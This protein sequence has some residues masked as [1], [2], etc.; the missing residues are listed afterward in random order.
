MTL[1]N[2]V[3][4]PAMATRMAEPDYTIGPRLREYHALR[5]KNGC[6]LNITEFVAVHESS[7]FPCTPAIYEDRFI[8]GFRLL[9]EELHRYG[10]RLCVQLWHAGRQTTKEQSG[11]DPAAPSA[12]AVGPGWPVPREL[13][14]EEIS[15]LVRAFGD[16]A[17][18]AKQAGADA[19]EIH[20][21][22]GYLVG[23]FV[24]AW[25]NRRK[26]RY[27]GSLE[28]RMTFAVEIIREIRGRVG[29]DFPLIYRM[30]A[31]E[32][33]NSPEA[34]TTPQAVA[35]AKIVE[36]AGV[37]AVHVSIGT[38]GDMWDMIPP[39]Q[40]TPGFNIP[41]AAAVKAA[42]NI[43]V[44]AVGR[45]NFPALADA[46]LA[47]GKADFV[48]I[49][50]GQL[51]DPEFVKKARE[52]RAE[53]IVKCIGC[54]Q[55]CIGRY[56]VSPHGPHLTCLQNPRCGHEFLS[57]EV[58]RVSAQDRIEIHES[59]CSHPQNSPNTPDN[60]DFGINTAR[61]NGRPGEGRPALKRVLVAGG[62]IAGLSAARFLKA[63]GHEVFLYEEQP[64]CGGEFLLAGIPP[65]KQEI[66]GAVLWMIR[67]AALEGITVHTGCSVDAGTLSREKPEV[68]ILA[69]GARPIKPEI[70]GVERALFARD[71]LTG[72]VPVGRQVVIIG[73]GLVGCET[74]EYLTSLGK[75]VVLVE[76]LD[77]LAPKADTY[78]RHYIEEYIQK[79]RIPVYLQARCLEIGPGRMTI[80]DKANQEQALPADTVVIAA[81]YRSRTELAEL[82]REQGIPW[83]AIGDA[84]EPRLA[85]DAIK[86]AFDCAQTIGY[87]HP[88]SL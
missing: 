83:V 48:S 57:P 32:R 80:R 52:G 78:K 47:E 73:G 36:A 22:H 79:H 59:E 6:A 11:F 5:A 12:V 18:R 8:P 37:D 30:S 62:G 61:D 68:L 76:A 14:E 23:Q 63:Q 86:E 54:N 64:E 72:K 38:Y 51:A 33:V 27:G 10:G 1:R 9:A 19:V 81:G 67:R 7:H 13:T 41:N 69:T 25:S 2:R 55:G 53:D 82:A 15:A 3:I 56:G 70:P 87:E 31:E 75:D 35:A 60:R 50:R 20:G 66:A 16:A 21:A 4:M 45:I 43:P 26:D 44:I 71:A 42:V 24:S 74:A 88:A 77:K 40:H 49:G 29:G 65:G 28:N 85:I 58:C 46:I 34:M 84:K 39:I 17:V